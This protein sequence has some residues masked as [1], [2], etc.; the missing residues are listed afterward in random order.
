MRIILCFNASDMETEDYEEA[1]VD[2]FIQIAEEAD[3]IHAERFIEDGFERLTLK[4]EMKQDVKEAEERMLAMTFADVSI[5]EDQSQ[6]QWQVKL[7]AFVSVK[8]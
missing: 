3:Q 6:Q 8:K 5:P 1:Q 2:E 4:S 7:T